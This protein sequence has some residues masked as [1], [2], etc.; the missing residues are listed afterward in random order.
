MI[1]SDKD[2]L[3]I[4]TH[5]GHLL[6][7]AEITGLLLV[8]IKKKEQLFVYSKLK[9]VFFQK[10]EVIKKGAVLGIAKKDESTQRYI[11]AFSVWKDIDK[12]EP[13]LFINCH[14]RVVK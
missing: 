5:E 11:I 6:V 10:G 14:K 3:V 4:N 8:G 9:K 7:I 2:S 1:K 12:L 13:E